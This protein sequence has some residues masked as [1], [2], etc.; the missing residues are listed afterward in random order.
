MHSVSCSVV[1]LS[2]SQTPLHL[3]MGKQISSLSTDKM[4]FRVPKR[5]FSLSLKSQIPGLH[6][7]CH[8][9]GEG[10]VDAGGPRKE[11]FHLCLQ[12]IKKD[13]FNCGLN[14]SDYYA[15]AGTVM[16]PS[17]L[18]NEN[19]PRFLSEDQLQEVFGSG[20]LS[21]CL[22]KLRSGFEKVGIYHIANALPTFLH[23]FCPLQLQCYQGVSSLICLNCSFQRLDPMHVQM[24]TQPIRHL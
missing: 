1:D 15:F 5:N 23:I 22:R 20:Q 9:Y 4:S 13:Y 17:V 3:L 8:F 19:I 16:A 21:E 10:A 18:Q 24:T 11:F 2:M 7:R 14:L 6:W 12:E